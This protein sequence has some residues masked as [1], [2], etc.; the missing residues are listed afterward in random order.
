MDTP[1]DASKYSTVFK[2][3]MTKHITR[4]IIKH[5]PAIDIR[6]VFKW[7]KWVSLFTM[8]S[9][10]QCLW[11][12]WQ[13]TVIT[14]TRVSETVSWLNEMST[15]PLSSKQSHYSVD[16]PTIYLYSDGGSLKTVFAAWPI[17]DSRVYGMLFP[18]IVGSRVRGYDFI[19]T[20]YSFR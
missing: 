17:R 18:E 15:T 8:H 5:K 19:I 16:S 9:H 1:S 11:C 14:L 6:I 12:C 13:W 4:L 20:S 10:T 3:L 2:Q 7:S